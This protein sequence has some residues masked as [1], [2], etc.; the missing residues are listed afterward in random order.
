MQVWRDLSWAGWVIALL[1]AFH[2]ITSKK[3]S[4][5]HT[6]GVVCSVAGAVGPHLQES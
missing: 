3:W 5:L 2:G 4:D 6:L 1:V